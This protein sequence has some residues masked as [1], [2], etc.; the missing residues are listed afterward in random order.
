MQLKLTVGSESCA[1]EFCEISLIKS[2]LNFSIEK[3][4]VTLSD[5]AKS[6]IK[7]IFMGMSYD[8]NFSMPKKGRVILGEF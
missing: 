5:N 3:F 2:E 1:L 8:R 4:I 6:F 7:L